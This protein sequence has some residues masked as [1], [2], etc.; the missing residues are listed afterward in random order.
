M[1]APVDPATRKKV[2]RVVFISLLLDLV[3]LVGLLLDNNPSLCPLPLWLV[4]DP[5][6]D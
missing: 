5:S 1:A 6:A 2:L 4:T 3:R